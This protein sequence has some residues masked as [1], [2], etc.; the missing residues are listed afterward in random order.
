MLVL[1]V[2]YGQGNLHNLFSLVG[3]C[4]SHDV[5]TTKAVLGGV[6]FAYQRVLLVE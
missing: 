2:H 1:M 5:E 3:C 4:W 6:T